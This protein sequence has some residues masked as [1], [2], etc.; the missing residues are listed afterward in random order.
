[1]K[2]CLQD[3]KIRRGRGIKGD[4]LNTK[5]KSDKTRRIAGPIRKS[6]DIKR[7]RLMLSE[8]PRDLLLFDL[9]VQTG[10]GMKKLLSLRVK[11]LKGMTPGKDIHIST[12]HS[13]D[14]VLSVTNTIYETFQ[15]YV[16]ELDPEPNDY[17][18]R[19]KKG[20]RP[21]NLSSVSNMIN[22]WYEAAGVKECYGAIS[23]RKTWEY[24]RKDIN[25]TA[26]G[27]A[28]P[29]PKPLFKPIETPSAQQTVYKELFNAI[30]SGKIEPGTRLTTAEISKAFKV[31]QAPVRV[32][33]NWLEA[34]GFIVSQKKSGSIVKELTIEELHEIVDI[35]MILETA[36]ARLAY[37]SFTKETLDILES[38]I[39]RY[40]NADNFEEGD[41]LNRLFHQTLYRDVHMPLL[42]T[43][44]TDLYDR[45][46]PY[47]ILTFKNNSTS[48]E[49]RSNKNRPEYYHLRILEGIRR[50][51][52]AEI[53]E[54]LTKKIA[55][56]TLVTEAVL[57]HRERLGSA[58]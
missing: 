37:K 32:A 1:L 10:V 35:R 48:P 6:K 3:W 49:P 17:L 20:Q 9:A 40:K 15:R 43:M 36:A 42:T 52:L 19:S 47:A 28:T 58:R 33:L 55:R 7:I 34:K 25:H 45:F 21:L 22:G 57:K 27:N 14:L 8:K 51:N 39:E 16:K 12:N 5:I 24:N 13:K 38:I 23:L 44:I 56:A 54:H 50:K 11:S 30:V 26:D 31:S 41:Q 18:F 46:S 2:S 4:K 29:R 53:L